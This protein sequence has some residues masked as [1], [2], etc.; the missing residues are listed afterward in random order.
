MAPKKLP[1]IFFYQKNKNII[2]S[3]LN[4][5]SSVNFFIKTQDHK[6]SFGP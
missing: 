6:I 5:K 1:K 4:K 2:F 3:N